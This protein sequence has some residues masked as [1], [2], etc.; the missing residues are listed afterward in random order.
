MVVPGGTASSGAR[1]AGGLLALAAVLTVVATFLPVYSYNTGT[2]ANVTQT[3]SGWW[4]S[5]V[6]DGRTT[7]VPAPL[8]GI[9]PTLAAVVAVVASGTLLA[10][11]RRATTRGRAF[12]AFGAGVLAVAASGQCLPAIK[13]LLLGGDRAGTSLKVGWVLLIVAAVVS[14]GVGIVAATTRPGHASG[15]RPPSPPPLGRWG[16]P[17]GW[18]SPP[19]AGP[20]VA[21]GLLALG[22]V[23]TMVATF[24][25]IYSYTLGQT[26]MVTTTTG[27]A[28]TTVAVD[29]GSAITA[30]TP[31]DGIWF[32]LVSLTAVAA[33]GALLATARRIPTRGWAFGALGAGVLAAAAV[34]KS[35]PAIRGLLVNAFNGGLSEYH[36]GP[37]WFLLIVAAG[38]GVAAGVL[39]VTAR[40]GGAAEHWPPPQAWSPGQ[41]PQTGG[42]PVQ[43]SPPHRY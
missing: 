36:A 35:V 3:I 5:S 4:S 34:D 21:G 27:W 23:L 12:G 39:A 32:V 30:P 29:I 41:P 20:R 19:Q 42:F 14:V 33:S 9:W 17:Q 13:W 10:T 38:C 37:G 26:K 31:A 16:P 15:H 2:S 40:P 7:T 22:A 6:A 11:A 8:V 43:Q 25:P 18:P 1:V 28:Q 24:L